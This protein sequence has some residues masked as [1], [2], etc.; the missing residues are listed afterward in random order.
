LFDVVLAQA[1]ENGEAKAAEMFESEYKPFI[2]GVARRVGGQPAVEAVRNFGADLLLPRPESPPPITTYKGR[3]SLRNWLGSVVTKH[4]ISLNRSPASK[5][6]SLAGDVADQNRSPSAGELTECLS[7]LRPV[8]S[9]AICAV[10]AEDRVLILMLVMD[11]VPQKELAR[12]LNI[13]PGNVTRRR[14]SIANAIWQRVLALG[15]RLTESTRFQ[16]CL[17]SV[18]S[19]DNPELRRS[20]GE[21]V[22][23]ALRSDTASSRREVE[24]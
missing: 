5:V 22:A 3:T 24:P 9:E 1:F 11:G 2:E 6:Q 23:A 16:E 21:I 20:M 8:L 15:T 10:S 4:L 19:G 17:E 7:L 18:L 13:H 12:S 14:Q